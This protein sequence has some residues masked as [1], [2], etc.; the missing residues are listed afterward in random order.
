VLIIALLPTLQVTEIVYVH[1]KCM[2]V[3]DRLTIIGS[4]KHTKGF[5]ASGNKAEVGTLLLGRGQ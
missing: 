2:I 3:D 5:C 1:S 4:G